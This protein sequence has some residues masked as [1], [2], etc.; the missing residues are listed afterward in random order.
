MVISLCNSIEVDRH[1]RQYKRHQ[2]TPFQHKV[3][4]NSVKVNM[5]LGILPLD[6]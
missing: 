3:D 1:Q 4:R 5:P 6:M 2:K